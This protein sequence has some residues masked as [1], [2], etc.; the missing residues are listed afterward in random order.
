MKK[1]KDA[2]VGVLGLL[3]LLGLMYGC[4]SYSQNKY[5]RKY[6]GASTLD[7]FIDTVFTGK[8]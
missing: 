8:K 6:P 3:A 4:V 7:W 2:A 5:E 1:F